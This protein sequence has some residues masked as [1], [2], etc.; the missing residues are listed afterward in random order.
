MEQL[1]HDMR[2]G[3]NRDLQKDYGDRTSSLTV[4]GVHM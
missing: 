2:L 3:K 1:V 4:S